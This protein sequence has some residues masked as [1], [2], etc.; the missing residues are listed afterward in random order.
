MAF[1]CSDDVLPNFFFKSIPNAPNWSDP[2]NILL[3]DGEL[4]YLVL[5]PTSRSGGRYKWVRSA[6][7]G[8]LNAA[9]HFP[10]SEG[11]DVKGNE[12]FLI[13]K[14]WNWMFILNLDDGTYRR[15][16]TK[17]GLFDGQPDQVVLV[18][19]DTL[20]FTEDGGRYAGV[21]AKDSSGRYY[22]IL[23]GINL[24]DET[25]GLAFR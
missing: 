11:I 9:M 1:S 20:Y 15:T 12:L 18:Y 14:L 6:F 16:S 13:S 10:N 8:S 7:I 24:T 21:H 3:G 4:D 22:P 5:K 19:N 17:G 23:E 2:W 25:T